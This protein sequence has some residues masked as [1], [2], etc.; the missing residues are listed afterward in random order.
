MVKDAGSSVE[1][2]RLRGRI[3]FHPKTVSSTD[4][5]IQ[6]RFHPSPEGCRHGGRDP[7][8]AAGV[9]QNGPGEPKRT[10]WWSMAGT[11][12]HNSTKRPPKR[13]K[14]NETG[15]G[16]EKKSAKF[17]AV[18]WRGVQGRWS[19]GEGVHRRKFSFSFSFSSKSVS[20]WPQLLVKNFFEPSRV[21]SSGVLSFSSFLSVFLFFFFSSKLVL[22]K[23]VF[24]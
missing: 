8:R 1:L 2:R 10:I 6:R 12:G 13:E 11:R 22:D 21:L 5:F 24:G 20:F 7:P 15:A 9:S 14:K 18:R 17:W 3:H 23:T 4:T 19:R 16:E